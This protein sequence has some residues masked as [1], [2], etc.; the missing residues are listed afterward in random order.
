MITA[1]Y[2]FIAALAS[3][4]ALTPLTRAVAR[5]LGAVARP[6]EDRW[7]SRPTALLGGVA[8]FAATL[9]GA[10]AFVEM[11]RHLLIVALTAA[12]MFALGLVDDV[13]RLQPYQKL[14]GQIVLAAIVIAGGMVLPWTSWPLLNMA[15]TLVWIIGITNAINLLDNMDGLAAGVSAIAAG[16]LS[17][18]FY[19]NGQTTE[20]VLLAALAGG[21]VS[22][23]IYNHQP[24]SIFMGDCGSLFIGFLL[25]TAALLSAHGTS[26]RTRSLVPVLIVPL[27]TLAIPIFDT[28]LVT[29]VRKLSG[30]AASQ[31]GRDHSSHRLVALGLSE[32][33]AVWM[34]WSIS[35]TAGLVAVITRGMEIDDAIATVA[36]FTVGLSLLGVYLSHLRVYSPDQVGTI[37]PFLDLL[38]RITYR[39]RVAEV[40]IDTVLLSLSLYLAGR[41]TFGPPSVAPGDWAQLIPIFVGLVALKLVFFLSTGVYRGIWKYFSTHHLTTIVRANVLATAGAIV[42]L[43]LLSRFEGYSRTLFLVDGVIAMTLM[44]CSRALF[45]G[46]GAIAHSS[47]RATAVIVF[48]AGDAGALLVRELR[49]N[50][51]LDYR[52]IGFVDDD[53]LKT[54]RTLLGLP[55]W[56]ASEV[57]MLCRRYEIETVIISTSHVSALRTAELAETLEPLGVSL[58]R[59]TIHL[60][61]VSRQAAAP[62]DLH[63][64]AAGDALPDVI[65]GEGPRL[66]LLRHGS[67]YVA[68]DFAQ[69]LAAADKRE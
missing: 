16:F 25:A 4:A 21:L 31:G 38:S 48:G 26:G 52:A 37:H 9:V 14:I 23:L 67:T 46:M 33:H 15:I 55:V 11:E 6:R 56:A 7:H 34:L 18:N 17:L 62:A 12:A 66:P 59:M 57:P 8:I 58:R 43:V 44:L 10:L 60:E 69:S 24:A 45:R 51:A 1:V 41:I 65:S 5:R 27:L 30:R 3:G 50:R 2:A 20:A 68:P 36:A 61:P 35:F 19:L 39:Q 40:S 32:R 42:V 49:C 47:E 64:A 53:P 63:P 28:T 54:G 13:F 22:F 29:L